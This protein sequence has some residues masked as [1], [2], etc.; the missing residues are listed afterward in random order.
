MSFIA[1]RLRSSDLCSDGSVVRMWVQILAATMVMVSLSKTLYCNC[2]S[3]LK[4]GRYTGLG[5]EKNYRNDVGQVTWAPQVA[6]TGKV[7]RHELRLLLRHRLRP[8]PLVGGAPLLAGPD[9]FLI[10]TVIFPRSAAIGH[11]L[12][13]SFRED[14][15]V[16]SFCFCDCTCTLRLCEGGGG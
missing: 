12:C 14:V 13:F 10:Y 8:P 11:F 5:A 4:T 3:S 6:R 9:I 7:Q 16:F 2:F 15:A 1:E